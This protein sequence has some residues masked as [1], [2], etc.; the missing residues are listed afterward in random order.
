MQKREIT[1]KNLTSYTFVT[2]NKIPWI[3]Q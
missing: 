3:F 2:W 1:S